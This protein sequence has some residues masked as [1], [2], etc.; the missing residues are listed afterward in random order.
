LLFEKYITPF[1]RD[2]LNELKNRCVKISLLE[3]IK[4]IPIYTRT[5]RELCLKKSGR[6]KKD[7]S[8]VQVVAK[9]ASLMSTNITTKKYVDPRVQIVAILIN[10]IFVPNTLIDLGASINVTTMET[11]KNMN[12]CNR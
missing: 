1:E 2:F 8:M 4:S 10:N 3:A 9:T 7:P 12:I 11:L 6:K 5:I